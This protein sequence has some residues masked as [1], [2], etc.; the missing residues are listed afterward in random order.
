MGAGLGAW[1]RQEGP[2]CSR[3]EEVS[4]QGTVLE[5]QEAWPLKRG[6][7]SCSGM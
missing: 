1:E 2:L 6:Q 5:E 7:P 4:G 3:G